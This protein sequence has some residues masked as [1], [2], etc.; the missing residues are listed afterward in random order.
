MVFLGSELSEADHM[1]FPWLF[2][3]VQTD[4]C[5]EITGITWWVQ[6]INMVTFVP[7]L[8]TMTP[9]PAGVGSHLVCEVA[10][11][12]IELDKNLVVN[13]LDIFLE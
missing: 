9:S 6:G 4:F 12:F 10:T 3:H 1:I 2:C 5:D 7:Q 11:Q 8:I 13:L